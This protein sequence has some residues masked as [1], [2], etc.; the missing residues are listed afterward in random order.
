MGPSRATRAT[1]RKGFDRAC[2]WELASGRVKLLRRSFQAGGQLLLSWWGPVSSSSGYRPMS[3]VS[4]PFWHTAGM[5]SLED[6]YGFS[7]LDLAIRTHW[8]QA[9]DDPLLTASA[10][11]SSRHLARVWSALGRSRRWPGHPVQ[12]IVAGAAG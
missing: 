1:S 9:S 5:T 2:W 12:V 4:A 11:G 6:R 10:L 3:V 8:S 7:Q